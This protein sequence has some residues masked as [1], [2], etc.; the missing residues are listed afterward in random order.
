MIGKTALMFLVILVLSAIIV[1][2]L[3]QTDRSTSSDA[4]I[5]G[6]TAGQTIS[7]TTYDVLSDFYA[8]PDPSNPG[9]DTHITIFRDRNTTD[10]Y[11][12]L[13]V[14]ISSSCGKKLIVSPKG[15]FTFAFRPLE[16]GQI[17]AEPIGEGTIDLSINK[18]VYIDYSEIK[19]FANDGNI[20]YNNKLK[21]PIYQ[22]GSY[23]EIP[24]IYNIDSKKEENGPKYNDISKIPPEGVDAVVELINEGSQ[25]K[26]PIP[27][28]GPLLSALM[29]AIDIRG[30][31]DHLRAFP[32]T[33]IGDNINDSEA[34]T[35]RYS[36]ILNERDIVEV[37]WNPDADLASSSK[38]YESIVVKI[39]IRITD[40]EHNDI[41]IHG[42]YTCKSPQKDSEKNS[43]TNFYSKVALPQKMSDIEA[44]Q[45]E[46]I[47]TSSPAEGGWMQTFGGPDSDWGNSVR[48]TSDGGYIITGV[49]SSYG[50][51]GN[52]VWLIK[53]DKG[54]NEIWNK[55]FGGP[56]DDQG[57]SVEQTTDGGYIITG[58]TNS[59]GAGSWDVWLIRTDKDGNKLWDKTFGGSKDDRGYS[60]QETNDGGYIIT[61]YTCSFGA[62]SK[63]VWLIK[64]DKDGNKLWSKTFGGADSDWGNSVQ[65]TTDGGYIIT[66]A[67]F[68]YGAGSS[69]VWLIKTDKD[70][71]K[72]WDKTFGG[73]DS[74][75]GASVQQTADGGF[76][77]TGGTNS[78]GAGG[79]DVWLIRT[80]KDGNKLWDKTFGGADNDWGNSVRQT[81]DGGYIITGATCSYGAGSSA[82]WLIKTDK[83]GNKLWDKTFGG[84]DSDWGASVQQTTD[85]GY[86]ITGSTCS[87]G[88]GIDDVWLI[89]TDK[90]GNI[91]MPG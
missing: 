19:T 28:I 83:D 57:T 62:G 71:N 68:S 40:Q 86:I 54:G 11:Q 89:K 5:T 70:G 59:Y 90:D 52:D 53:T 46:P 65:Q 38:A 34:M 61:G 3:G 56:K 63:D 74:D 22:Y 45:T 9:E 13:F 82:V 91:T 69:A 77:I 35:K 25:D 64:T 78:Y 76:I 17:L 26:L 7:T 67:T 30:T 41:Y 39:P 32:H 87:Y 84:T 21:Y 88:A 24:N 14:E 18:D 66:G 43:I 55:T 44:Q 42:I 8:E 85:G 10:D 2:G 29:M 20:H 36:N 58:Y 31:L 16:D 72:L 27:I 1:S 48:Q 51:G 49:T 47:N 73:T 79:S 80:D 50:A 4:T 37:P 12:E 23:R 75:W 15:S 33:T 60:V 81:A 6:N